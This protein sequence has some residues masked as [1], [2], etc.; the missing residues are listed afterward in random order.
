MGASP[1]INAATLNVEGLTVTVNDHPVGFSW[2]SGSSARRSDEFGVSHTGGSDQEWFIGQALEIEAELGVGDVVR[3]FGSP[4]TEAQVEW[5]REYED[6]AESLRRCAPLDVE[7]VVS[8]ATAPPTEAPRLIFNRA[9]IQALEVQLTSCSP[10][11]EALSLFEVEGEALIAGHTFLIEMQTKEGW[12]PM[13][14]RHVEPEGNTAFL[15]KT[16]RAIQ[17][18]VDCWRARVID[19]YGRRSPPSEVVCRPCRYIEDTRDYV[20]FWDAYEA[21]G[22]WS[23]L[24]DWVEVEPA[25][26]SMCFGDLGA[27]QTEGGDERARRQGGCDATGR[28][29]AGGLWLTALILGLWR[30]R[31][32]NR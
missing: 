7:W 22:G 6:S 18:E 30:R 5:E 4:C 32:L 25:R 27:L 14:G 24:Y 19:L 31:Q 16:P 3:L 10:E 8:P 26:L 13:V 9:H 1:M 15:L 2:E 20:A 23:G 29:P 12:R 21:A 28:A 17:G 11:D